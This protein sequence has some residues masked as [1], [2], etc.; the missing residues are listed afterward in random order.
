MKEGTK[1]YKKCYSET[2]AGWETGLSVAEK[3]H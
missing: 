1:E 3:N 2:K